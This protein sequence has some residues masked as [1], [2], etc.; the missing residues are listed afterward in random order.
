MRGKTV[1]IDIHVIP[2]NCG[3][4]IMQHIRTT[5]GLST[6]KKRLTSVTNPDEHLPE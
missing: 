5:S 6:R 1:D 3:G 2:G 4:K